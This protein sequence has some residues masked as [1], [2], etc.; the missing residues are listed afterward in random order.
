MWMMMDLRV[1]SGSKPPPGAVFWQSSRLMRTGRAE[2]A[3]QVPN[4]QLK[5]VEDCKHYVFFQM[6][7]DCLC[8][9]SS[10]EIESYFHV[11]QDLSEAALPATIDGSSSVRG[12]K[13]FE[14]FG[15]SAAQKLLE[16]LVDGDLPVGINGVV[17]MDTSLGVGD[18]FWAW[19]ERCKALRY[20]ILYLG[21]T[22]DPVALE[23]FQRR[24]Q[25][26][27]TDK[28]LS[29]GLQL[30]GFAPK[31]KEPPADVLASP[32]APPQLNLCSLRPGPTISIPD[33]IIAERSQH[34]THGLEFQA[35]VKSVIDEFGEPKAV[36]ANGNPA[37][38]A[39]VTE[40]AAKKR[41]LTE[42]VEV[43][44]TDKL[45]STKLAEAPLSGLKKEAN[46]KVLLRVDEAHGWWPPGHA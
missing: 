45:P 7:C 10:C 14:Q 31:N 35:V 22:A 30:P 42:P 44:D 39:T 11:P 34:P 1:A 33:K 46:G 13:R 36:P 28:L 6:H 27:F 32:P 38:P 43:V 19:L 3:D 21:A 20:P 4:P 26:E 2:D 41:R 5:V 29:G 9:L 8:L 15:T 23:W 24:V 16:S 12:G 17:M 25:E 40:P 18:M 37:D